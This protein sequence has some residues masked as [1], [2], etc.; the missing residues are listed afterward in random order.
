MAAKLPT[1]L[2]ALADFFGLL[3][4]IP[5]TTATLSGAHTAAVTTITLTGAP[6]ASWPTAGAVAID[7]EIITYTGKGATTLTDCTR[8]QQDTTAAAHS[9]GATVRCGLTKGTVNQ[10]IE[11]LIQVVKTGT[12]AK[13]ADVASAAALNIGEDGWYFHVTGTTTI[14]SIEARLAGQE[15][16]LHFTGALTLTHNATSLI[17]QGGT[18]LTTAAGDVLTFVSEGSGNWREKSRRLA[19]A[20]G[21]SLSYFSDILTADVALTSGSTTWFDIKTRSLTAGTWLISGGANFSMDGTSG[22]A[23]LRLSDGTTHYSSA[24]SPAATNGYDSVVVPTTIVVLGATTTVKLQAAVSGTSTTC[25][26]KATAPRA[27]SGNT[28][29]QLTCVKIG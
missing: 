1:T 24:D 26:V 3:P 14:T 28:A 12:G 25:V 15:V 4:G 21:A 5:N 6:P 18:N 27:A 23:L 11:E 16:T 13:G 8:G 22:S 7:N 17:L 10:L 29:T 19:A 9:D 2:P 20:A